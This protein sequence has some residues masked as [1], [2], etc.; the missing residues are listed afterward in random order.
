MTVRVN[1]CLHP[2]QPGVQNTHEDTAGNKRE[3]VYFLICV[4][5]RSFATMPLKSTGKPLPSS[6]RSTHCVSQQFRQSLHLRGILALDHDTH[7]RLGT[8][9]PQ[10]H[11][12][13]HGKL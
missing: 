10:Q 9:G 2:H 6:H 7:H 3:G 4:Y 5:A 13:A 1:L 8:G 11:T 12:P